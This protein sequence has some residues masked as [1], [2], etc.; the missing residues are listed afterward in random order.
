MKKYSHIHIK[1]EANTAATGGFSLLELVVGLAI[2]SIAMLAVVS[3]FTTLTRSYTTQTASA[4]LQQKAR[5]GLDYMA[6]NIRMAGLNPKRLSSAGI[7]SADAD[8]IEFN[9][10]RNLNG[11]LENKDEEHMRFYFDADERQIDEELYT[12]FSNKVRY[13][14]VG[15]VTD[16]TFNYYDANG[17]LLDAAPEVSD[18]RTV[19]IFVTVQQRPGRER[20]PVSRTYSS[21]I[22]CRNLG[23]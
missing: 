11:A 22:I 13:P 8:S 10:D 7:I 5:A 9:L 12:G 21:R 14:L 1:Y 15:D 4:G 2:A 23:L 6:Q 16:L 20:Q 3:V 18:I 19:E 17:D